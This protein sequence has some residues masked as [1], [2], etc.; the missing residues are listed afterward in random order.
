M[1]SRPEHGPRPGALNIRILHLEDSAIDAELIRATLEAEEIRGDITLVQ[2]REDFVRAIGEKQFD[3]ILSDH[4]LPRFDG[5]SALRLAQESIPETPFIYV[6]G[7]LGEERAI[8]TIKD[9]A[10][11]YVL[12]DRLTRLCPAMRRALREAGERRERAAAQRSLRQEIEVNE[13]LY[14]IGSR[15]AAELDLQKLLQMITEET[16]R[17]TGASCGAFIDHSDPRQLERFQVLASVPP[18]SE[19]DVRAFLAANPSLLPGSRSG[20]GVLR[21]ADLRV[22]PD[23]ARNPES[24]PPIRSYLAIPVRGRT[25]ETLGGL[26]FG[27][28][29]PGR[30]SEREE[31]LVLG[32]A[33]QA[34]VA[35]DNAR[36]FLALK[37]ENSD[38]VHA[39]AALR[40]SEERFRL[41]MDNSPAV[42]TIKNEQGQLLYVNRTFQRY[43]ELNDREAIGRTDFDLWPPDTARHMRESDQAVLTTG[44]PTETLELVPSR[45]G[46]LRYWLV[47]KFPIQNAAGTRLLGTVGTDITQHKEAEN[48]I[49]EQAALLD[50]AQDAICV[51]TLDGLVTYTNKSTENLWPHPTG[52][53]ALS[54]SILEFFGPDSHALIDAARCQVLEKG[55]WM[56]ELTIQLSER[57]RVVLQSHWTLVRN[58]ADL[59]GAILIINT[60]ITEKKK[61]E[62]QFLRAQRM[63]SI[64]TLAGGIAHDLNN[65]LA[66]ILMAAQLLRLKAPD[67]ESLRWLDT[68]ETSAQRG[69]GL[70][71]QV[72]AFA[73][74]IDGERL[75]LQLR[76]LIS[77]LQKILKE[78]FP[79]SIQI[80]SRLARDLW[81]VRADSTQMHQILMNLCVNARDAMPN[82][83]QLE[84]RAENIVV[85]E[86]YARLHPQAHTGA[87]VKVTVSDTGTGMP[88]H[89]LE[90]IFDPFFTTKEIGKGTGLGLS[91]VQSIL[92][93]HEGF[94]HVYSESGKGSRF[95]ICLPAESSASIEEFQSNRPELP[96]GNGEC[97][98]IVDDEAAIREITKTMLE[99]QNYKVLTAT[100]GTDGLAVFLQNPRKIALVL[101]DTMMP[102]MDGPSMIRALRK[103]HPTVRI[104][105]LSGLLQN[106]RIAEVLDGGEIDFLQKPFTTEMLL[107]AVQ[108][109]LLA[110]GQEG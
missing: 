57:R 102:F 91:T 85:D 67:A 96:R 66:P 60:D 76:H 80:V 31:H 101:V 7:S 109:N 28:P 53:D 82:G 97:I 23:V 12:K 52:S 107:L 79:R 93:S 68:V 72:L 24:P 94:L 35:I 22:H 56:G 55:E 49:R 89:I 39:E 34:S 77:E 81:T 33:S 99:T 21:I 11:D 87:Y 100:D 25:Q 10:T 45:S 1:N 86:V 47:L 19:S 40:E 61:L 41:F 108:R 106:E 78:T 62:A 30:F 15:L 50:K 110:A 32:I 9:G 5:G 59:P 54:R 14:R 71:K 73:R 98:L 90:R 46:A 20:T 104:I 51:T 13:T 95:E 105:V 18:I 6:T 42:A 38:R 17:L 88:P 43:L 83:G 44:R 3:I 2:T 69:A 75:E 65:I 27:H 37:Q 74:G 64:G 84:I 92:R 58:E 70:I 26:C 63:E 103:I 8:D 36:L 16:A 48:R 4:G 29:E